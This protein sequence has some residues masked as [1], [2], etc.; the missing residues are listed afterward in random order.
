MTCDFLLTKNY[1]D[2]TCMITMRH[3]YEEY[4]RN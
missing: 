3:V 2:Q 4:A 1:I